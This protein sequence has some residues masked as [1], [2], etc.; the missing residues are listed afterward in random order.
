MRYV[1]TETLA[2]QVSLLVWAAKKPQFQ[3]YGFFRLSQF[4]YMSNRII[5]RF[6]SKPNQNTSLVK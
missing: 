3:V 6:F 1:G 5:I 4:C 2:L